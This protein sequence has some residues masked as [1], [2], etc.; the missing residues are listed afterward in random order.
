MSF[1]YSD[2]TVGW[3]SALDFELSAAQALLDDEHE[4]LIALPGDKNTYSLGRMGNHNVVIACLPQGNIGTTPAAIVAADLLRSF[5]NVRLGFMVGIGGGVPHVVRLGDIV[6]SKPENQTGKT[7]TT[8]KAVLNNL[9]R[10][11]SI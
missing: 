7:K 4:D 5:P 3:I 1:D 8:L 11:N 10:C 6:V 2:Y 9:R